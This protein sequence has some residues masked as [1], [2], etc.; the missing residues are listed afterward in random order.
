M[1]NVKFGHALS[2][3][4]HEKVFSLL[5]SKKILDLSKAKGFLSPPYLVLA[6]FEC[7]VHI[8]RDPC[9]RVLSKELDGSGRQRSLNPGLP[10]RSFEVQTHYALLQI[11]EAS[12]DKKIAVGAKVTLGI[13]IRRLNVGGEES[14]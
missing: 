7:S 14:T 9:F 4:M 6:N 11:H 2:F 13:Y 12:L 5:F 8:Y 3:Y 10:Y 1:K